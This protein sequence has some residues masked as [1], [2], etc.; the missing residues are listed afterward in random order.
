LFFVKTNAQ[1]NL[2]ANLV[3]WITFDN[4]ACAIDDEEGDPNITAFPLGDLA[5]DCGVKQNS[6]RFDGNDDWFY[7]VGP[8]IDEAFK[9]VDFSLSFYF[10]AASTASESV[11][12][13][14]KRNSCSADSSF[15]VRY[16][17]ATRI[18]SVDLN[19]N[20]TRSGSISKTL[21]YAC[22]Y[23]IVI[24]RKGKKTTLY[25]NGKEEGSI[26][27]PGTDTQRVFIG[28]NQPLIVGSSDCSLDS[29]FSG[30]ID[31]IRIY[32][33]AINRDEVKALYLLPDAIDNGIISTGIKDTTIFLGNS[34]QAFITN[35]CADKFKW[36]PSQGVSDDTI[37]T[38][39]LTPTQTTTYKLT[40]FFSNH[41]C[42]A[43]DS[44]R[45]TVIDPAT[46]D[47]RDIMLPTAFTP[48]GDG[49]NDGFGISNPFLVGE[50]LSFEIFDR[51]GSRVFATTDPLSKWD[52]SFKGQPV[53]AGVF[54]YKIRFRCKGVE[55]VKTGSVTVLR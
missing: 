41:F 20:A 7:L 45:I 46:L 42:N 36:S 9:T 32:N 51:W 38:P 5:C 3:A 8:K 44:L 22:W 29:D 40:F 49:L 31:E 27:A 52:G 4:P 28:N 2:T 13:F 16:N 18:L 30:F 11:A 33:R 48:N 43:T 14:S 1:I 47:C 19:E 39:V 6:L 50:L 15:S 55:D 35:T 23:H 34:V 54:L 17:P 12:L 26:D 37:A 24:V 25:V 53:N 10:K 21:P